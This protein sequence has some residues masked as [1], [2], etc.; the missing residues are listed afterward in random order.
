MLQQCIAATLT[1]ILKSGGL[2]QSRAPTALPTPRPS[3]TAGRRAGRRG[4]RLQPR[5]TS[6]S[7]PSELEADWLP[8]APPLGATPR[9]SQWE[10]G[11]GAAPRTCA[12]AR[13][14]RARGRPRTPANGARRAASHRRATAG[15]TAAGLQPGL[16]HDVC[17]QGGRICIRSAI[18]G[19]YQLSFYMAD[20]P[21]MA[22]RV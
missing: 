14:E 19:A 22:G 13:R 6:S 2:G 4:P 1:R 17:V 9:R 20:T 18:K 21:L 12:A 10:G 15:A 3:T 16:Q 7:G 8:P 11:G 5:A